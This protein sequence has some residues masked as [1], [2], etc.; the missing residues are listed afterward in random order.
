MTSKNILPREEVGARIARCKKHG[1][2]T[3]EAAVHV[4]L[5]LTE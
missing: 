5:N 1:A 3:Q 4:F 2:F